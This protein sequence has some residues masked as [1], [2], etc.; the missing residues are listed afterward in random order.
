[1]QAYFFHVFLFYLFKNYFIYF[2]LCFIT[3]AN[4]CVKCLYTTFQISYTTIVLD[5]RLL[6]QNGHHYLVTSKVI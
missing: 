6:G 4:I 3:I 5:T 2:M 1:M